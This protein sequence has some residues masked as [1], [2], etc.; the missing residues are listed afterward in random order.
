MFLQHAYTCLYM[1]AYKMLCNSVTTLYTPF[2][3]PQAMAEMITV[4][5]KELFPSMDDL[6]PPS[7]GLCGW[8]LMEAD[9]Y[10]F[11]GDSK[12]EEPCVLMHS[13]EKAQLCIAKY[14]RGEFKVLQ[15]FVGDK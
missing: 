2:V 9:G 12:E 8:V 11:L 14:V 4:C 13:K 7:P 15:S 3:L 5:K 6:P 1:H 10:S